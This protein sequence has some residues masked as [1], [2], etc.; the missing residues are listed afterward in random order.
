[1]ETRQC[2]WLEYEKEV[3][4]VGRGHRRTGSAVD[5]EIVALL[6]G[7]ETFEE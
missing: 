1:M 3:D 2:C 4:G 6:D 7:K 5:G